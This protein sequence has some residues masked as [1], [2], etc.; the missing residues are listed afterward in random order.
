[1]DENFGTTFAF[2][3]NIFRCIIMRE[4]LLFNIE[5]I[6]LILVKYHERCTGKSLDKLSGQM[7]LNLYE[8]LQSKDLQQY[9]YCHMH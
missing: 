8:A 3:L 4:E 5:D 1:M 2:R 6:K 7:L 9:L